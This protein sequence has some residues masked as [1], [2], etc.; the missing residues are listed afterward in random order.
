MSCV[1]V[2]RKSSEVLFTSGLLW[3]RQNAVSKWCGWWMCVYKWRIS[4]D[5]GGVCIRKCKWAL[6]LGFSGDFVEACCYGGF[7]NRVLELMWNMCG[8][9]VGKMLNR[10][11]KRSKAPAANTPECRAK[12]FPHL[13]ILSLSNTLIPPPLPLNLF[14]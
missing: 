5:M 13:H 12:C 3:M 9:D 1:F 8:P 7:Y 14:L 11:R 10:C 2:T 6:G 4:R